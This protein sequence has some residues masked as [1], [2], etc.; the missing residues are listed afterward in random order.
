MQWISKLSVSM[1]KICKRSVSFMGKMSKISV[2]T[3]SALMQM[4]MDKV[5]DSQDKVRSDQISSDKLRSSPI[6]LDKKSVHDSTANVFKRE[7]RGASIVRLLRSPRCS[8]RGFGSVK[9][10]FNIDYILRSGAATREGRSADD[11]TGVILAFQPLWLQHEAVNGAFAGVNKIFWILAFHP[12]WLQHE[13]VNGAAGHAK[14]KSSETPNPVRWYPNMDAQISF[15]RLQEKFCGRVQ[16]CECNL[17]LCCGRFLSILRARLY[18]AGNVY[19]YLA[20]C[21]DFPAS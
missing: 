16:I 10:S 13:A 12:L 20:G 11:K 14:R 3:Q 18:L 4:V 7:V 8:D 19:K 17:S 15:G 1:G 21:H 6:R 9:I 2:S 5:K